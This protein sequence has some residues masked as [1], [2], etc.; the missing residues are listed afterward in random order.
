MEDLA[1]LLHS[2][3][4][5]QNLVAAWFYEALSTPGAKDLI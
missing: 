2:A 5:A 4:Q 3:I 1:R